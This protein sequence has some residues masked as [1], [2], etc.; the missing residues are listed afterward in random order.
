MPCLHTH[1]HICPNIRCHT[2]SITGWS[3]L[4]QPYP[5]A[6]HE[7][8]RSKLGH[9]L[10]ATTACLQRCCELCCREP[11]PHMQQQASSRDQQLLVATIFTRVQAVA[12]REGCTHHSCSSLWQSAIMCVCV[13]VRDRVWRIMMG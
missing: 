4:L 9:A 3:L 13:C 8:K 5:E 11:P 6:I 10:A 1:V 12:A 2:D 7:R